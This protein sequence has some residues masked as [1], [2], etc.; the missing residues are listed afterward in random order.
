MKDFWTSFVFYVNNS[1]IEKNCVAL[2]ACKHCYCQYWT[3]VLWGCHYRTRHVDAGITLHLILVIYLFFIRN[4]ESASNSVSAL[5]GSSRLLKDACL[6]PQ[7][8][9]S[10]VQGPEGVPGLSWPSICFGTFVKPS[11]PRQNKHHHQ[12]KSPNQH[13]KSGQSR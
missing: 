7:T 1:F 12:T 9:E 2:R 10:W 11:T 5:S 8:E 13:K 4:N 6:S 3:F